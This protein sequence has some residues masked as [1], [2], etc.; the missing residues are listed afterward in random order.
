MSVLTPPLR[1]F[2]DSQI[3]GVMCTEPAGAHPLQ[4]VVYYVRDDERLLIS[5]VVGRHK[6]GDVERGG[7][8]SLC[9]MGNE[10]PFP[11]A[12]FSGRAEVLTENIGPATAALAQRFVGSEEAP[13]PQTDEALASVGRIIVA[14]AIERVAAVGHLDA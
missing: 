5:S 10:R 6:V 11:S 9:V 4:S 8:A 1:E 3:V 13:Q 14:I 7:W 2:L 12:T